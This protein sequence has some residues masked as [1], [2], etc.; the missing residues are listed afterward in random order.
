MD[1][2][3]KRG[4]GTLLYVI[5]IFIWIMFYFVP[6]AVAYYRDKSNKKII[7]ILNIVL[8][9]TFFGWVFL[10]VWA[11][12]ADTYLLNGLR[13]Q[14]DHPKETLPQKECPECKSLIDY[15]YTSCPKCGKIFY[16]LNNSKADTRNDNS[17]EDHQKSNFENNQAY[18]G[19]EVQKWLCSQCDSYNESGSIICKN[20]GTY[21][22]N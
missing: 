7:L 10:L 15:D 16:R 13:N 5:Y 6:T 8:G 14:I 20:C 18:N 21:K 2:I 4:G 22:Y 3:I 19:I 11:F 1:N 17:Y 9:W 12:S